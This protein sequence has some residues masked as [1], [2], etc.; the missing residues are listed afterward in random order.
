MT[1]EKDGFKFI[2]PLFLLG[3]V[4][5]FIFWPIGVLL[6]IMAVAA[7]LFFREVH[8]ETDFDD[9]QIIAPASGRII[10]VREV[11]EPD[12]IKG[13]AIKVSIFMSIL[14]EHINYAPVTGEVAYLEHQPGGFKKAYLDAASDGNEAQKIGFR[15]E[16]SSWMM[17]QIAGVV[18]R[19]IVCRCQ[20]REHLRAG[21]KL[22]LIRFGS[23]VEL[24]FP[25]GTEFIITPGEHI[26]GG[27]TII[28]RLS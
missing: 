19:R 18:A 24:F 10:E 13:P 3:V 6:L 7:A 28:G 17:K 5:I 26:K 14:D 21:E 16:N 11:T 23:R 1:I 22:G 2:I 9:T 15:N 8:A 4:F 25:P 27:R 20:M 12:Y